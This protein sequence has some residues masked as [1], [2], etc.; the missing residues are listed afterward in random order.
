MLT[1]ARRLGA[2]A[3]LATGAVH[4]QQYVV[5]DF[6]GIPTIKLL[7][8]LNVI[9][10]GVVGLGLL[11]PLDRMLPGR[12]ADAAVALL[13]GVGLTIAVGSLV[14]L[15]LSEN[16]AVFGLR[17]RYY[18][19]AAVVAIGAEGAALLLLTPV[20]VNAFLRASRPAKLAHAGSGGEQPPWSAGTA[21]R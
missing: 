6:Q 2:L 21:P 17:T 8:L 19:T 18:S 14:A 9:G 3:I 4:L 13:A 7:F 1:L 11:A 15:F 10:S 12:W 5:Q 16:E 20:L